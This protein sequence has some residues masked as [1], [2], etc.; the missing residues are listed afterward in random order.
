MKIHAPR[1]KRPRDDAMPAMMEIVLLRALL[2]L[3]SLSIL[4]SPVMVD[5]GL[6]TGAVDM[7]VG[8]SSE[9]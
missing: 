9:N 1:I 5:V 3:F 2:V 4:S 6:S 8:V 7:G